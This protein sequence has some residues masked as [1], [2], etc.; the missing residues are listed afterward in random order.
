MFHIKKTR[1]KSHIIDLSSHNGNN[2]NDEGADG[3]VAA[4][5]VAAV[6]GHVSIRWAKN[7]VNLDFRRFSDFTRF[8]IVS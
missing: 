7:K 4:V 8:K 5:D 1:W 6:K 2:G 3:P